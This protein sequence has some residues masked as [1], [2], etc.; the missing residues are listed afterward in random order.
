MRFR[1]IETTQ[2][3]MA[4]NKT[5]LS[6]PPLCLATLAL[7]IALGLAGCDK[8]A[9]D[10][11]AGKVAG[12]PAEAAQQTAFTITAVGLP[13]ADGTPVQLSALVPGAD[14]KWAEGLLAQGVVKGGSF[15][16]NASTP[17]PVL[18]TLQIGELK[19]QD[20]AYTRLV[21]ESASYQASI[22]DGVLLVKG[23]RYNDLVFGYQQLPA[24]IA[25]VKAKDKA[26]GEALK[27]VDRNDDAAMLRAKMQAAPL[28]SPYY[29]EM[30]KVSEDYLAGIVD[31]PHDDLARFL[32]LSVTSDSQR[33]PADR[34]ST[35]M[36]GWSASLADSP[37]YQNELAAAELEAAAAAARDAL[38][39]GK[40]Y[41][42]MTV[43]DKDGR[44][45]KLST[46]LASNK[47]VLLD[48]WASWCAPCREEF[49]YLSRVYRDYH[50]QGF[51]IYGVSLD[52]EREDWL[53]AMKQESDNGHLPWINLR[54]DGFGSKAAEAYGVRGLPN[55]FL[56]GSDGTIVGK[57][58]RGDEV[59]RMVAKQLSK[60]GKG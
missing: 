51:E 26:E 8:P 18:G 25:A 12:A 14:G 9:G 56:I 7:S 45:V 50:A 13:Q 52:E 32:A 36:A 15:A 53:K 4:L 21:V 47:F 20:H 60:Q 33:Y 58:M 17:A 54:A 1:Q 48:F 42:D 28:V 31:G 16:L 34:R 27:G 39:V 19:A 35:L 55:N 38:A 59:E 5:F 3:N 10:V 44:E 37:A 6:S 57:N 11:P 24:Y 22:A 30:G 2:E 43:A 40:P 23:G 49:P 41:Q 29:M 46:V